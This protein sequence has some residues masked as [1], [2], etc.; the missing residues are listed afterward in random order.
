MIHNTKTND[1]AS[2]ILLGVL[3]GNQNAAPLLQD[4]ILIPQKRGCWQLQFQDL[5]LLKRTGT[6][7]TF[8][9]LVAACI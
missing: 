1:I 2:V 3:C 5:L 9:L 7:E 6:V 4:G 8:P